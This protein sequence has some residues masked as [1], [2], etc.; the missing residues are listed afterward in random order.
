MNC[1]QIL[2]IEATEDLRA[3]KR[4]YSRLL[5]TC[6][7]DEDPVAFQRLSDAYEAA[8]R[9]A[10]GGT[11]RG[12]GFVRVASP[13]PVRQRTGHEPARTETMQPEP[14]IR[15]DAQDSRHA[16]EPPE[17]VDEVRELA[18]SIFATLDAAGETAAIEQ[19]E[20]V[21]G[22]DR[23]F[24]LDLKAA[25]E[26]RLL[27]N[28]SVGG[29]PFPGRLLRHLAEHYDWASPQRIRRDPWLAGLLD[30]IESNLVYQQMR[31]GEFARLRR[32]GVRHEWRLAAAC[33]LLLGPCRPLYFRLRI[34]LSRMDV[35]I[36]E[37][38]AWIDPL[39][40]ANELDTDTVRWWQRAVDRYHVSYRH[41]AAGAFVAVAFVTGNE[42]WPL[43]GLDAAALTWRW[44]WTISLAT[45]AAYGVG[46]LFF[47]RDRSIRSRLGLIA[48]SKAF[49]AF[50]LGIPMLTLLAA[51]LFPAAAAVPAGLWS[52]AIILLYGFS[53]LFLFCISVFVSIIAF[54][55]LAMFTGITDAATE[56]D[57][58]LGL[59]SASASWFAFSFWCIAPG[60]GLRRIERYFF[61]GEFALR[62]LIFFNLVGIFLLVAFFGIFGL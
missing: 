23:L 55:I 10:R 15:V 37:L 47:L 38:F 1:W 44:I 3:I 58:I 11:A 49:M 22:S 16:D 50:M 30:R 43:E 53:V 41:L 24:E 2:G 52:L 34:F 48:D 9:M 27:Q 4:A 42:R 40:L 54:V 33:R 19:F 20:R 31:S 46:Y 5:K 51:L 17:P 45:F 36:R 13:A 61:G 18:G 29:R 21:L 57:E 59:A 28:A 32:Q 8:L 7:P 14:A 62:G 25:F 35:S 26:E 39:L 12:A 6:R 56:G 60:L